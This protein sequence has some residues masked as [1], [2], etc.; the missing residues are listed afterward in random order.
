MRN[1]V[2]MICV[3][4]GVT[5]SG[6]ECVNGVCKLRPKE[7]VKTAANVVREIL[8]IPRQP[9]VV[10]IHADPVFAEPQPAQLAAPQYVEDSV[11]ESAVS[12]QPRARVITGNRVR[13][14]RQRVARF[15]G[16]FRCWR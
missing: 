9:A 3:C 7:V 1:I 13:R 16:R 10:V 15:I 4:V 12:H 5:A 2:L 6:Q 14:V 8:P 11:Q